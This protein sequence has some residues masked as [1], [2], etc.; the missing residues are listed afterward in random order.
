MKNLSKILSAA[1]LGAGLLFSTPKASAGDFYL[2]GDIDCSGNLNSET[3]Y[4]AD[5]QTVPEYVR[6]V[7]AHPDDLWKVDPANVAPIADTPFSFP[8]E[9]TKPFLDFKLGI[10]FTEGIFNIE[11]GPRFASFIDTNYAN[12]KVKE[13]NYTNHPGTEERGYGAALTFYRFHFEK[14]DTS[15]GGFLR[16]SL[17][18]DISDS[19]KVLFLEPFLDYSFLYS[20]C[21]FSLTTG[22][23][24]YNRLEKKDSYQIASDIIDH[25]LEVGLKGS[26]MNF[27]LEV[28]GGM[29]IPQLVNRTSLA[30][31]THFSFESKPNFYFGIRTRLG[32]S[33]NMLGNLI[34]H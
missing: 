7:P 27:A 21:S 9:I 19:N 26:M 6:D 24:R 15:I 10:G 11:L 4:N 25:S 14:G 1:V 29:A 33:T 32:L 13:R 34:G 16:T 20:T 3:N 30:D 12:S 8:I 23:D 22:W 31:E 2:F 17:K 5:V 18:F 28:Y